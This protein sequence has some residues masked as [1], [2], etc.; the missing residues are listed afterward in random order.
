MLNKLLTALRPLA[1]VS[2]NFSS[3]GKGPFL[4][5]KAK[6]INMHQRGTLLVGELCVLELAVI[7]EHPLNQ[8]TEK[9]YKHLATKNFMNEGCL[10]C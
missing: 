7:F 9:Y 2:L 4:M 8:L 6:K 10:C 3:L 5:G 1:V